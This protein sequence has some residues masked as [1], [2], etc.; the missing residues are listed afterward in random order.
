MISV[1]G[2]R[3]IAESKNGATH[4][5]RSEATGPIGEVGISDI[6]GSLGYIQVCL[7]DHPVPRSILILYHSAFPSSDRRAELIFCVTRLK[8]RAIFGLG[9]AVCIAPPGLETRLDSGLG[10]AV[11]APPSAWLGVESEV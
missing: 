7:K 10:D 1:H 3:E 8:G 11:R 9:R 5:G 6:T 2:S 4:G